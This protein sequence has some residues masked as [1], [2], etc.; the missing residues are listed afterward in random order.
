MEMMESPNVEDGNATPPPAAAEAHADPPQ[1]S[2]DGNNSHSPIRIPKKN[3]P[4]IILPLSSSDNGNSLV[5]PN[6]VQLPPTVTPQMIEGRL[7]RAFLELTPAQMRDVLAEYDDAV[8]QKGDEIRNR[9]AYLFGVVKRYKV[10]HERAAQGG[11]E[12]TPQGN[13]SDR[14]QVS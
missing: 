13:L 11:G 9:A 7:R 8:I 2:P 4:P 12:Y 6:G 10:V 3:Q 14:V 5:L 1:A